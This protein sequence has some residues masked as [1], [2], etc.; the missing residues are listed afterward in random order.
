MVI[1]A[2]VAG[3][4]LAVAALLVLSDRPAAQ[5]VTPLQSALLVG[6][7]ISI[8]LAVLVAWISLDLRRLD[9]SCSIRT[10]EAEALRHEHHQ[11]AAMIRSQLTVLTGMLRNASPEAIQIMRRLEAEGEQIIAQSAAIRA[12]MEAR[13]MRVGLAGPDIR[14]EPVTLANIADDVLERI[15]YEAEQRHIA[16]LEAVDRA[17]PTKI[18]GHHRMLDM[19]I[20]NLVRNAI[21]YTHCTLARGE[22][23]YVRVRVLAD[24]KAIELVVEDSG[25]GIPT[26]LQKEI[27]RP[28]IR[29]P[30]T[31]D[32]VHGTGFGLAIVHEIVRMHRATID[33]GWSELGG[34]R[35]RVRIPRLRS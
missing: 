25:R 21:K 4:Y 18:A 16:L 31:A 32:L 15:S 5:Q 33:V 23:G 24:T 3:I 2:V 11:S 26:E 28:G 20:D 14:F 7:A 10:D 6:V 1:P 17:Q 34:A 27:F 22:T 35:F 8:L 13:S 30:A 29:N 19:M 9:T 12:L